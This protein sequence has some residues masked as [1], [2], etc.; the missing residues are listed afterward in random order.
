MYIRSVWHP[1]QTNC[2]ISVPTPNSGGRIDSEIFHLSE[3]DITAL[4]FMQ[5]LTDNKI[6]ETISSTFACRFITVA[7]P[8]DAACGCGELRVTLP[9]A[10]MGV[11]SLLSYKWLELTHGE[12]EGSC[13]AQRR[14]IERQRR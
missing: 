4:V 11:L 1:P 2:A 3:T 8:V 5:W 13:G 10:E 7:H 9:R 14:S 6:S 12:E